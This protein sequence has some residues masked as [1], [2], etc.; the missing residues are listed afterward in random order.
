MLLF[1]CAAQQ[2]VENP[3]EASRIN[4]R[5]GTDYLR[6][7]DL[8]T[9]RE[10]LE[11][12]VA[13]DPYN[14]EARSTLA[15]LYTRTGETTKADAAYRRALD[16]QPDDPNLL[17]NYGVFLCGRKDYARADSTFKRAAANVRYGAPEVAY[18]NAG[19]CAKQKPDM[20]QAEAYF[21]QAL[22]RNP[23]FPDALGQ[24]A[25]LSVDSGNYL[26]A[27]AFLQ[28]YETVAK[29]TRELM[30]LGV[31]I[32]MALGDRK[33]ADRYSQR[34]KTEFPEKKTMSSSP[35]AEPYEPLN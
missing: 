25:M 5:L 11:K 2:K 4:T 32:E 29:P 14:G 1:G 26:N 24:M 35:A 6:Q 23:N 7:G 34:L 22:E 16:L 13:Q 20:D 3:S 10:K 33:A 21:R 28:R 31:R 27:R 18:T 12:A 30:M 17:N 15:L 9:A 19:V 8:E